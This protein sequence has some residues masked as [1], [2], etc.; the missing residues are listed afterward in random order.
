MEKH[1]PKYITDLSIR[2][3]GCFCGQHILLTSFQHNIKLKIGVENKALA[4]FQP[5]VWGKQIKESGHHFIWHLWTI[6]MDC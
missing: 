2:G 3:L 1:L 6:L 4:V 5:A